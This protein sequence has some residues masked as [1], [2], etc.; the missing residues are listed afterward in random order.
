M[1]VEIFRDPSFKQDE[2]WRVMLG[3]EILKAEWNSKGAALAGAEVELRRR[4]RP[5]I[6]MDRSIDGQW[7]LIDGRTSD[8]QH[9]SHYYVPTADLIDLGVEMPTDKQLC[10]DGKLT[11]LRQR[12][13]CATRQRNTPFHDKPIDHSQW[14]VLAWYKL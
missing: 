11:H 12:H 13:Y 1:K 14:V 9:Y 8:D 7:C 10:D 6:V 5:I 3:T 4:Q 2:V